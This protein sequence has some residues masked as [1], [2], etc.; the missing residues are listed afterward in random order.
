VFMGAGV[1][2]D[3]V[4]VQLCWDRGLNAAQE[5]QKFLVPVATSKEQGCGAMANVVVRDTFGVTKTQPLRGSRW[6]RKQWLSSIQGLDLGLLVDA[7]HECLVRWIEVKTDDVA[8]L[9]HKEGIG[10]DFV[11]VR[12]PRSGTFSGGAAAGQRFSA[13]DGPY[14]WRSLLLQQGSVPSSGWIRLQVWS[15]VPG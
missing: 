3:Q 13:S 15:A 7:K 6:L 9:T 5:T 10:R 12:L 8:N 4:N 14:F 2:G 1:V 11:A